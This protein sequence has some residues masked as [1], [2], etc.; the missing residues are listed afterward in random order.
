[1][2]SNSTKKSSLECLLSTLVMKVIFE[3]A[4][5]HLKTS[6]STQSSIGE[7]KALS[8]RLWINHRKSSKLCVLQIVSNK[9]WKEKFW[10]KENVW[11]FCWLNDFKRD[12][13]FD[14]ESCSAL[15][16][17]DHMECLQ[18]EEMLC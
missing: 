9:S 2:K 4:Q 12:N 5:K 6:T 13:S 7:R 17:W 8:V 18:W 14:V 16:L 1:M 10:E 3:S 15:W 11:K